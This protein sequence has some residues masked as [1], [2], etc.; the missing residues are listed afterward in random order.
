MLILYWFRALSS[1]IVLERS[2]PYPTFTSQEW[3]TIIKANPHAIHEPVIPAPMSAAL[4]EAAVRHL[5]GQDSYMDAGKTSLS[6]AAARTF[7]EL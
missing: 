7:N 6:R 3:E 5:S 2:C 4:C 1:I